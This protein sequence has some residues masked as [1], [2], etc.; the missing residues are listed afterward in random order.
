MKIL[1]VVFNL[2]VTILLLFC[3]FIGYVTSIAKNPDDKAIK[4]TFY[5]FWEMNKWH[6][7]TYMNIVFFVSLINFL[8]SRN[9]KRT[10][11]MGVFYMLL[12]FAFLFWDFLR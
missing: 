3:F 11:L 8:I 9:V 10:V 5:L 1:F 6:L 4:Y 2:F 12:I 7:I